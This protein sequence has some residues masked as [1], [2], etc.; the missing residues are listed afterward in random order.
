MSAR[1][2]QC[3]LAVV[4]FRPKHNKLTWRGRWTENMPWSWAIVL[5]RLPQWCCGACVG[6]RVCSC[7]GRKSGVYGN[8]VGLPRD[9][10]SRLFVVVAGILTSGC[11][12]ARVLCAASSPSLVQALRPESLQL[13]VCRLRLVTHGGMRPCVCRKTKGDVKKQ[14]RELYLQRLATTVLASYQVMY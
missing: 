5:P 14:H 12:P 2:C 9:C 11:W 3:E 4:G 7:R 6:R 13:Q 8:V 1:K 10:Y